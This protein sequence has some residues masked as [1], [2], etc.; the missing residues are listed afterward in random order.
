MS[1]NLF[2][3]MVRGF[4][5]TLGRTAATSLVNGL[6]RQSRRSYDT[7][8]TY[9]PPSPYK[10]GGIQKLFIVVGWL[11]SSAYAIKQY[12]T[13]PKDSSEY[14]FWVGTGLFCMV[15][16]WLPIWLFFRTF[17]YITI[18]SK[19]KEE[20]EQQS[21]IVEQ[22]NT[23]LQRQEKERLDLIEK[24][25][26]N[27][28]ISITEMLTDLKEYPFVNFNLTSEGGSYDWN[29]SKHTAT[30]EEMERIYVPLFSATKMLKEYKEKG[31]DNDTICNIYNEELWL[32]MTEEHMK[33]MKGE[34]TKTEKETLRDGSI[35]TKHIY[36]N[37][38]SGDVLVFENDKLVSFKDR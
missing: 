21:I 31:Y 33:D 16:G 27:L 35:R 30:L 6:S 20:Q 32:G 17:N 19:V 25:K 4:G 36:G 34:P 24:K 38:T 29:K 22:R 2:G 12:T 5:F 7:Q 28:R 8:E 37:K 23:E 18:S 1:S 9:V 13:Y 26:N 15:L 10:T 11:W 14:D 3:S